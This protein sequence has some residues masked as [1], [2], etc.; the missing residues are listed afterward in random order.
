MPN[1][2][3]PA[4][5]TPARS[6][7]PLL[8][9]LGLVGSELGVLVGSVPVAAAGLILFGG[10]CSG[11]AAEAGYSASPARP[12]RLVGGLFVV[13][14]AGLRAV[15]MSTPTAAALLAPPPP[16]AGAGRGVAVFLAGSALLALGVVGSRLFP[17]GR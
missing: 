12:L 3:G 1:R 6:P 5:A 11:L 10:G 9:A 13:V 14:G 7:W 16:G 8:A 4:G 2:S 15:Q 17:A